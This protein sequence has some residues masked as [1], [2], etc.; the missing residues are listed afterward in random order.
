VFTVMD[1]ADKRM[2]HMERTNQLEF[3]L[4][5]GRLLALCERYKPDAVVIEENS[6]GLPIIE[7]LRR[8]KLYVHSFLTTNSSK[9]RIIDNLA[10]H[11]ERGAIK[12]LNDTALINELYA[13]TA[14]KLP[15]GVIRYAAPEGLHD[16]MVIS[17][18]LTLEACGKPDGY[19]EYLR[20]RAKEIKD[21]QDEA[22]Q[23]IA[24]SRAA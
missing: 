17:L 21:K 23:L 18:A 9:M 8:D 22:Q 19:L 10:L 1:I 12:I 3:A 5:R 7:Q 11:F 6:I 16:D 15:S 2:V 20:G 24:A 14:E 4:Q 13:F